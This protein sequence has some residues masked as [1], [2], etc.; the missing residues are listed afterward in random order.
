MSGKNNNNDRRRH[1]PRGLV[2][3]VERDDSVT[4]VSRWRDEFDRALEAS[5]GLTVV[6]AGLDEQDIVR[7]RCG[8]ELDPDRGAHEFAEHYGLDVIWRQPWKTH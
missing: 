8:N 4:L 2:A 3:P 1:A 5:Y 6:D 7:W